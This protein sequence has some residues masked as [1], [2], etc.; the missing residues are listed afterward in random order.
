MALLK[1]SDSGVAFLNELQKLK[2]ALGLDLGNSAL[3][4]VF[5]EISQQNISS[6]FKYL[7]QARLLAGASVAVRKRG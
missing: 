4:S 2:N 7:D 1:K 6:A 3:E 5:N